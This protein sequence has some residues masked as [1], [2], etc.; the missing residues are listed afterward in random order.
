MLE[1]ITR[2]TDYFGVN[3]AIILTDKICAVNNNFNSE[4]FIKE[5]AKNCSDKS[6]TQRVEVIA[7]CLKQHLPKDYKKSTA[8]LRRIMGKENPGETG[9]FKEY[10]WLIPWENTSKSTDW[11]IMTSPLKQLKSSQ[12]AIQVNMR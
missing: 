5:V 4:K 7:D 10:Y 6:L 3:L 9:M 12:N 8:I 2:P 11:N 1:K